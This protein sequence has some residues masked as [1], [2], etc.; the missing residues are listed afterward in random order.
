MTSFWQFCCI[1]SP[2]STSWYPSACRTGSACFLEE[3]E[4]KHYYYKYTNINTLSTIKITILKFSNTYCFYT[5]SF[6]YIILLV[7]TKFA[8]YKDAVSLAQS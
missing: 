7:Q 6:S 4:I 2:N 1:N 8:Q 3:V 5:K